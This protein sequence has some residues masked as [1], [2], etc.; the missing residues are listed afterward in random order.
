MKY[1][2][3]CGHAEDD[4]W[5]DW[6]ECDK[7]HCVLFEFGRVVEEIEEDDTSIEVLTIEEDGV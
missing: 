7:C 1:I 5:N 2:C 6:A 4:H 3:V